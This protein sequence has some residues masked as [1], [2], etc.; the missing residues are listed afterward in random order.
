MSYQALTNQL[1]SNVH[2]RTPVLQNLFVNVLPYED[3]LYILMKQKTSYMLFYKHNVF[4]VSLIM[5]M[6]FLISALYYTYNMLE[7]V[8]ST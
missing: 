3:I 7:I 2:S 5:L 4:R 6:V 1:L 8:E